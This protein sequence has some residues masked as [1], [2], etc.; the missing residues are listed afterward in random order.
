V[1]RIVFGGA[2]LRGNPPL[3]RWLVALTAALGHEPVLLAG[4]EYPGALGALL[5]AD[6]KG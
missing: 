1:R 3:A 4:G 5:L 2:A 6:A